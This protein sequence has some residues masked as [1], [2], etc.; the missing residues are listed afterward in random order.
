LIEDKENINE[1]N[2]SLPPI[3]Q[4]VKFDFEY[5]EHPSLVINENQS[6]DP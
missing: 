6:H 1:E 2:H 5:E 3:G 4:P